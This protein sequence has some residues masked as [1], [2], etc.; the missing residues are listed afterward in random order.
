[1]D[2]FII[3]EPSELSCLTQTLP[4]KTFARMFMFIGV[5]YLLKLF[6]ASIKS[7]SPIFQEHS[8]DKG[9]KEDSPVKEDFIF[10]MAITFELLTTENCFLIWAFPGHV[11]YLFFLF[12]GT[13]LDCNWQF[14]HW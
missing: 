5:L 6:A 13:L 7:L 10:C 11:L 8:E 2:K 9:V 4:N 14:S 12:V 3:F 1:M